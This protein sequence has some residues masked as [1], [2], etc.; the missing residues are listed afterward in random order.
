MA[1][2]R[3]AGFPGLESECAERD[4]LMTFA[5]FP[6]SELESVERGTS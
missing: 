4:L 3:F 6:G 2:F 5:G 1:G